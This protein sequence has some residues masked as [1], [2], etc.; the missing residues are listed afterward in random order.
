MWNSFPC[1]GNLSTAS[2]FTSGLIIHHLR[3]TAP[4]AFAVAQIF[5][6]SALFWSVPKFRILSCPFLP[7]KIQA[8][9]MFSVKPPVLYLMISRLTWMVFSVLWRSL[10][11]NFLSHSL[12]TLFL[13][14]LWATRGQNLPLIIIFPCGPAHC[15][16]SINTWWINKFINE[17]LGR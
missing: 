3:Y 11:N 15:K 8:S 2:L 6:T 12:T 17:P 7:V 9:V 16:C 1:H 4:A 13:Q 14:R 10:Y 5:H